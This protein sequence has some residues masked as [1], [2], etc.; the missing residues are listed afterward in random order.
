MPDSL[1]TPLQVGTLELRNRVVMLPVGTR[2][3]RGGRVSDDDIAWHA[4]RAAGGVAA[5]ITGGTLVH[6]TSTLRGVDTGLIE[7]FNRDGQERQR[8]RADAVH[9]HGTRLIGQ[10]LHLGRETIGA[11]SEH[12][13]LAPSA[14]RSSRTP[15]A[16]RALT[17]TEI[18]AIVEAF[19]VS[20]R[21]HEEAG[22]DGVE[23]H[24]AHGYLVAQFLST[25]SNQRE[26]EYGSRDL[27]TRMRFLRDV[28]AE[29]RRMC[30]PSF[31]IGVRL[32]VDE[33]VPGGLTPDDTIA[34]VRALD[35][36]QL[37]Y[38]SL[39]IGM[40][41]AYVKDHAAPLGLAVEQASRVKQCTDLPVLVASR[42][43]TPA[44]ARRILERGQADI[45]GVARALIADPRWLAKAAA[46]EEDRIRPCVG[47]VQ[48]CRT[49]PGG[50]LC[51]VNA[52]AGRELQWP[53]ELPTRGGGRRRVV[54]VGGGPAGMEAARLAAAGGDDVLLLEATGALGGEWAR[55]ALG[56]GR[57]ELG[58]LLRYLEGELAHH[59]VDVRLAHPVHAGDPALAGADLVVVA[60]GALPAPA[61]FRAAGGTRVLNAADA[62]QVSDDALAGLRSV[63]VDDGTGSWH[64]ASAAEHLA[65]L[66]ASTTIVTPA[67]AFGNAIPHESIAGLH[68]RLLLAGAEYRPFTTVDA[69][70]D[71]AASLVDVV[72]G[73]RLTV[74]A[75]I[76]VFHAGRI[77]QAGLARE[78]DARGVPVAEIGD[79]VAPRGV[80][81]AL[82]DANRVLR[83][84]WATRTPRVVAPLDRPAVLAAAATERTE[85]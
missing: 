31:P 23:I 26:D 29:V 17:V 72:T 80:G 60:T 66:C 19:G 33:E 50:A 76:V 16:P 15:D 41:G 4:E 68:E 65:V 54:V 79:C 63:L 64:A 7:A 46:G 2:L 47:F 3:G 74:E 32:S 84:D 37:A 43:T 55:A 44:L 69:V 35:A 13:Q 58:G 53:E 56:P 81:D 30:S 9:A 6:P 28:L 78:L 34:I 59:R 5:I 14:V 67:A 70:H 39:T 82:S 77:A 57:L 40:R 21:M 25:A 1:F 52:R 61:P 48:E 20:A 51:G 22:L 49:A 73:R 18:E 83:G 75:E 36:D 24:A 38:L 71:G 12:P 42:I 85:Q 62:L 27:G 8:R 45:V 10:I 11:Q